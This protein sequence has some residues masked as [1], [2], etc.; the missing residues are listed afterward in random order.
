MNKVFGLFLA[1][2]F[3]LTTG[4]VHAEDVVVAAGKKITFD[5]TLTVDKEV[6]ETS[7]GKKP[8]EYNPGR[9]ELIP[10]LEKQMLGMKVGASKVVVV[11]PE[12]GYGLVRQ[13]A[14]R[15]FD[16]AKMPKDVEPKVG[17]VLEMQDD[18]GTA[19]PA[20]VAEV[21]EKTV[22]LNF[23]HPLAGKELK[24]DVKVVAIE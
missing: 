18:K 2:G 12:D 24:F 13:D 6:V 5:Y 21:N 20:V 19:F 22:K 15:D 3:C 23:N 9:G 4:F 7:Q 11:K 17:M 8:L 14:F 10:G 1:A 16:R